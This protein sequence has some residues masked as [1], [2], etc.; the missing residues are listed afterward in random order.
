MI[1]KALYYLDMEEQYLERG[2]TGKL[3]KTTFELDALNINYPFNISIPED[4][5]NAL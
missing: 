2:L 5:K 4:L 1:A 3:S